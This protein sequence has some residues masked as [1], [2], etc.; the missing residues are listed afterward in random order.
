MA[1]S[2]QMIHVL[3]AE[4]VDGA[5]GMSAVGRTDGLFSPES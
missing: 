2:L 4:V 1:S 5:V 3:G